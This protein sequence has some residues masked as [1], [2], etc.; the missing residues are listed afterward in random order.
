MV[1]ICQSERWW[2]FHIH[3][4]SRRIDKSGDERFGFVNPNR[5][6]VENKQIKNDEVKNGK[7]DRP[8]SKMP[9]PFDDPKDLMQCETALQVM[10]R[11]ISD[12]EICRCD[13]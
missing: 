3:I 7:N 10:Q 12:G 2:S 1:R 13:G 4:G 8:V 6:L 11:R 9:W 5:A